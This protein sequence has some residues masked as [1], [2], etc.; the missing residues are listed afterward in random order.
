MIYRFESG[1]EEVLQGCDE[2]FFW[3]IPF[4]S[5]YYLELLFV[6]YGTIVLSMLS[7]THGLHAHRLSFDIFFARS[8]VTAPKLH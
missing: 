1:N 8:S 2:H 7:R 6:I 5:A 3:N 4:N